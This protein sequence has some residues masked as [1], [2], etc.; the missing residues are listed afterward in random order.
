MLKS[1]TSV[2]TAGLATAEKKA[3]EESQAESSA[4]E[5]KTKETIPEST[6]GVIT[7]PSKQKTAS[8][9]NAE[10][11]TDVAGAEAEIRL[12]LQNTLWQMTMPKPWR[13]QLPNRRSMPKCRDF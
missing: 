11:S 9:S 12:P 5:A 2:I 13:K 1:Q 8:P 3:K 6:S 4:A 7:A 10:T